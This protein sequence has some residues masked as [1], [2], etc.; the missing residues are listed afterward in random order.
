M[1]VMSEASASAGLAC[2]DG[3][4]TTILGV[5]RDGVASHQVS[6]PCTDCEYNDESER[7]CNCRS[8]LERLVTWEG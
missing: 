1:F 5:K 3:V 2:G 7:V 6:T 8:D 4:G